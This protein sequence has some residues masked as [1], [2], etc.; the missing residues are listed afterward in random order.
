MLGSLQTKSALD[1]GF[2]ALVAIKNGF[3][4][5]RSLARIRSCRFGDVT[6]THTEVFKFQ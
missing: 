2:S 6:L 5:L 4:A 3:A 1:L